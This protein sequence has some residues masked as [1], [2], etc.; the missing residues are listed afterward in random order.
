MGNGAC[1]AMPANAF[2]PQRDHPGMRRCGQYRPE[3][4]E[5]EPECGG[6]LDLLARVTRCR[7]AQVRWSRRRRGKRCR[8]PVHAGA[9]PFARM[10][11]GTIE[12][13]GRAVRTRERVERRREH[14]LARDRPVFLAQLDQLQSPIES[15]AR[16]REEVL[17]A[18]LAR[19]RDAVDRRQQERAEHDGVGGQ[20]RRDLEAPRGLP[21]MRL[22]VVAGRLAVPR[23]D[24]KEMELDVRVRIPIAL[25][26]PGDGMTHGEPELLAQFTVQR[27]ARR[28]ARPRVS[29]PET[30]NTRRRPFRADAAPAERAR[31][32]R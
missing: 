1:A 18:E 8:R 9:V 20:E 24:P 14:A 30:P 4:H 27:M 26:E 6:M 31:R 25:H 7:A 10:L 21:C 3:H 19:H 15:S 32:A 2:P 22:P 5:I 13:D 12:Q 11:R 28:L 17:L 29:R 16:A 23:E